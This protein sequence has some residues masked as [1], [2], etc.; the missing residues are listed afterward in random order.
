[1][2]R[3]FVFIPTNLMETINEIKSCFSDL[4]SPD[5]SGHIAILESKIPIKKFQWHR[6]TKITT[7]AGLTT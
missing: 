5:K 6:Q 1:M 2:T 3:L 4:F 7:S